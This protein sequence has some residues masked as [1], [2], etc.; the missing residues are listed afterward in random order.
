MPY[1]VFLFS[2]PTEMIPENNKPTTFFKFENLRIYFKA[3]DFA[4]A[5]IALASNYNDNNQTVQHFFNKFVDNALCIVSSIT[6]G[7]TGNKTQ[8]I[9]ELQNT[10]KFIR[11]C[12]I[13]NTLALKRE[14]IDETQEADIRNELMEL[15]K[16]VGALISSLQKQENNPEGNDW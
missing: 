3:I 13:Y 2:N 12:V 9:N 7:S 5:I 15:T 14:Y 16:M 1:G 11:S 6:D 8:F 4:D 10:K